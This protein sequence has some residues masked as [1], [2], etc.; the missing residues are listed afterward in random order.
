VSS[1]GVPE[2]PQFLFSEAVS[3]IP[4]EKDGVLDKPSTLSGD[5][6]T[7]GRPGAT[8]ARIITIKL[9]K[10]LRRLAMMN[11]IELCG[12]KI[13]LALSLRGYSMRTLCPINGALSHEGSIH[14]FGVFGCFTRGRA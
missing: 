7:L 3:I 4:A 9:L 10:L 1:I 11:P 5:A 12:K 13:W 14:W 2:S 8:K 6:Q